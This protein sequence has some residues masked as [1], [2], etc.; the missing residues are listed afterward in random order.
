MRHK[1][2]HQTSMV[3]IGGNFQQA[4]V[5][6]KRL[7]LDIPV[8][9]SPMKPVYFISYLPTFLNLVSIVDE[10]KSPWWSQVPKVKGLSR[11]FLLHL[12][13]LGFLIRR[14]FGDDREWNEAWLDVSVMGPKIVVY[15]YTELLRTSTPTRDSELFQFTSQIEIWMIKSILGTSFSSEIIPVTIPVQARMSV[16]TS[17]L[18]R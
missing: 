8:V 1:W 18:H 5:D 15:I 3:F 17:G 11:I 6:Y 2:D 10:L 7:L 9:Y 16:L 12:S 14:E 13:Q 4:M